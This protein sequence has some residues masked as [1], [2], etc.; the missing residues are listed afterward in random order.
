MRAAM[1]YWD[2]PMK[3]EM[4]TSQGKVTFFITADKGFEA[5]FPVRDYLMN[6]FVLK[7]KNQF[8]ITDMI[9]IFELGN[10]ELR[11]CYIGDLDEIVLECEIPESEIVLLRAIRKM[12]SSLYWAEKHNY[13]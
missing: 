2:Q 10:Y 11:L 9:A 12:V 8:G 6:E 5:F 4:R 7:M 1:N 3:Y 13:F